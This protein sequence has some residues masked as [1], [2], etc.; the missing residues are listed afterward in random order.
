MKTTILLTLILA[1]ALFGADAPTKPAVINGLTIIQ[2]TDIAN[3]TTYE[4]SYSSLDVGGWLQL[5]GTE[6]TASNGYTASFS[7]YNF[8]GANIIKTKREPVVTK[9]ADGWE[10][11]FVE[12]KQPVKSGSVVSI[13]IDEITKPAPTIEW[14]EGQIVIQ[15]ESKNGSITTEDGRKWQQA[16]A[17]A[18]FGLSSDGVV[19]WREV[20]DAKGQP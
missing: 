16:T 13:K 1:A 3:Y 20:K 7:S 11:R 6:K 17:A 14:L 10:I 8:R 5:T 9:T 19:V 2:G 18:Q 4:N 12:Q 15:R